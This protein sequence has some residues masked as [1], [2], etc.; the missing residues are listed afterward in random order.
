MSIRWVA[1]VLLGALFAAIATTSASAQEDPVLRIHTPLYKTSGKEGKEKFKPFKSKTTDS[2][3][4][5]VR[6]YQD[7]AGLDPVLQED[8]LPWVEVL[9]V[10]ALSKTPLAPAPGEGTFVEPSRVSGEYD[11]TLGSSLALPGEVFTRNVFF[12]TQVIDLDVKTGIAKKFYL[13]TPP[14]ALGLGSGPKAVN[15][16]EILLNG[17]P[18]V[19]ADGM[20]LGDTTGLKGDKGDKGDPGEAGADG[21]DGA[22]GADGIAGMNGMNGTNGLNGAD[23]A[24]G[25]KG[26]KGDPGDPGDPGADGA[27]GAPGAMGANGLDGA[28]GDKGDKG[29]PGD[30]FGGVLEQLAATG[31]GGNTVDAQMGNVRAGLDFIT[32]NGNLM[33]EFNGPIRVRSNNNVE[34]YRDDNNDDPGAWFSWFDNGVG[35]FANN[36]M[37][38]DGSNNLLVKGMVTPMGLDLAEAYPTVDAQLKP[39]MVVAVDPTRPEHVIRAQIGSPGVLGI[40]STAPGVALSD[41]SHMDG[42]RPE[43][44]AAAQ[45]ADLHGQVELAESLRQEWIGIEAARDDFVYVALAGRVP[46]QA[47]LSGGLIVAGDALGLGRRPGSVAKH[48]GSGPV[49]GMALEAWDGATDTLIAFVKLETG[50]ARS[51]AQGLALSTAGEG[52]LLAGQTRVIVRDDALSAASLSVVS[53]YGD[54]GSRSWIAERGQGYFVL[55]LAQPATADVSFGYQTAP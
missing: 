37:R 25:D 10:Q 24:K 22:P 28:K 17:V 2:F 40:V 29:D 50:A 16:T 54:P 15:A 6:L 46:V 7:K 11:L 38:L 52:R 41:G 32:A 43:L 12:T 51:P 19:D 26:D 39:G 49:L 5:V 44:L 8:T 18:L 31:V 36:V 47:D 23:G 48:T 27:P 34:M 30:D 4:V 20:W 3:Q 1:P 21:A 55:E 33:R 14:R 45:E 9:T 13:E 42:L 35:G 53:F